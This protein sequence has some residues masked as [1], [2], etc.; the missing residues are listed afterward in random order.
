MKTKVSSVKIK[1]TVMV[2]IVLIIA[3]ICLGYLLHMRFKQTIVSQAQQQLLAITKSTARNL[4]EFTTK[5]LSV[6]QFISK[7]PSFHDKEHQH[8]LLKI[9][10]ESCRKDE[11]VDAICLVDSNG[12]I[13]YRYPFWADGKDRRGSI[14]ITDPSELIC[15]SREQKAYYKMSYNKTGKLALFI[16]V[17]ICYE[18]KFSGILRWMISMDTI[19][20][21]FIMPVKVGQ[22]GYVW[23]LDNNKMILAHP[24]SEHIGEN[25]IILREGGFPHND[26]SELENIV[27]KMAKGEE[28]VGFY[29]CSCW[30][31]EKSERVKM[32]TAYTP[33]HVG[34]NSWSIIVS[35][36]YSEIIG[37]I[38]KSG[39]ITF[40]LS[41][42]IVLL[43]GTGGALLFI[44]ERK[45]AE[46]TVERKH[47]QQIAE[48]AEALR[49]SEKRYRTLV[50]TIPDGI[51]EIDTHGVITY[52]NDAHHQMF[53]YN[54]GK[55]LGK[56]IFDLVA[57]DFARKEL[58]KYVEKALKDKANT[59]PWEGKVFT[60]D[61]RTID[62]RAHWNY[63]RDDQGHIRGFISII[64]DITSQKKAEEA[65]RKSHEEL[66]KRVETRTNELVKE[67]SY[68]ESVLRAMADTLIVVGPEIRIKAVNDATLKLLGYRHGE[69]IAQKLQ[70]ILVD[71]LEEKLFGE[72]MEQ[73]RLMNLETYYRAK[74]GRKIP[75]LF[76]ATVIRDRK[77]NITNIVCT[78]KDST[79][80]KNLQE[81]L[82][83][84]Q[85]LLRNLASKQLSAQEQERKKISLEL[86]DDLGQILTAI[87]IDIAQAIKN[88]TQKDFDICSFLKR[89]Q[90]GTKEALQRVRNIASDL[91]PG[92]LDSL[93]LQA[94]VESFLEDFRER[95]GINVFEKI[96]IVNRDISEPV[97][98]A[99]YRILQESLTNVVKYAAA[100]EI[101][102][103]LLCHKN[104]IALSVTDDGKGFDIESSFKEKNLGL[105]G[106]KERAEWLNGVLRIES[107]PGHGTTIYA[108]IPLSSQ[109]KD[110]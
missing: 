20:R 8:R 1:I 102:V 94:A 110:A 24:K 13:S 98:I 31:E 45:K 30:G 9:L 12:A 106:I 2:C 97:T 60:K 96:H 63:D 47:L 7:E 39:L 81:S 54:Q 41:G 27:E 80:L 103:E 25:F 23:L 43:F 70:N 36:S 91:R 56:S 87:L 74:D 50:E 90:E 109:S 33:V 67:K 29:Y 82:L 100:K 61:G 59:N 104:N 32:L 62:I 108:E 92:I 93:G 35:T 79:E 77:G 58:R 73:G 53:G 48:A 101:N 52:A 37:P 40:I 55:L 65:L 10:Y 15:A 71:E 11:D 105:L 76:S 16:S 3:T 6:L 88:S 99:I 19:S 34:N 49:E 83:N 86:H 14:G 64:S 72:L 21:R 5:Y 107:A 57:K 28:G 78:G 18:G 51:H 26:W 44:T 89:I 85:G 38:N 68:T 4:E 95:T 22:K 84:F 69:L 42:L 17:P 75:I 46:L 66:E